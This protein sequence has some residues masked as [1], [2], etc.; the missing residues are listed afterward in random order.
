MKTAKNHSISDEIVPIRPLYY[1]PFIFYTEQTFSIRNSTCF[2]TT[3]VLRVR[4]SRYL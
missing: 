4:C 3:K 2:K 1:P